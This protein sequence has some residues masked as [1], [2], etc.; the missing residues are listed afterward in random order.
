MGIKLEG[1]EENEDIQITGQTWKMNLGKW[2]WWWVY[3]KYDFIILLFIPK[4]TMKFLFPVL[5][6]IPQFWED[7]TLMTCQ[8]VM[9]HITQYL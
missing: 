8:N 9:H 7:H 2:F 5:N 3:C 1:K 6:S 4:G